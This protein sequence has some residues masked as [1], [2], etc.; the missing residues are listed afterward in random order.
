MSRVYVLV[1]VHNR[2]PTTLRFVDCLQRQT[3]KNWQ[4]VLID[5]GSDDGTAAAVRQ[6][7]PGVT[8]LQGDGSLWWAGALQ[9]GY[10]WLTDGRAQPHDLVLIINDDTTFEPDLLATGAALIGDH[11]RSMLHAQCRDEGDDELLDDGIGVDW[12]RL[13]FRPVHASDEV[14]CLSTRGLLMT[15]E[16]IRRTG[17]FRP[18]WLPHYLSDYE[19]TLRAGRRGIRPLLDPAFFVRSPRKPTAQERADGLASTVASLFAKNNPVNPA[20]WFMFALL[21]SPW[22]YKPWNL[23]Q[24]GVR[25]LVRLARHKPR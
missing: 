5:D 8:I 7:L 9:L 22:V 24:V 15:V 11:P 6:V 25:T 20:A 12:R 17:G 3:H 10:R 1:P 18:R 4:L 19:F 21:A 2:R 16:G 13:A 23:M 14:D